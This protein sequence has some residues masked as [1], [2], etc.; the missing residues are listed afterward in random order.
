[1][2]SAELGL[3]ECIRSK[4]KEK[5]QCLLYE[6]RSRSTGSGVIKKHRFGAPGCW[7]ARGRTWCGLGSGWRL[8]RLPRQRVYSQREVGEKNAPA[9]NEPMDGR[10]R[11]AQRW[12][13]KVIS[14]Q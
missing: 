5:G 3:G 13:T 8:W 7:I 1:M 10:R 9:Q 14:I 2:R 4:Q 6:R 12:D 11:K